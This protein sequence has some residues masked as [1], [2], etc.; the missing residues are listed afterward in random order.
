MPE[1]KSPLQRRPAQVQ[2]AVLRTKVL[3]SIT[4]FLY[5]ERRG[6]R[7]VKYVDT[8]DFDFDFSGWNLRVL[9]LTLENLSSDLNHP[10]T[11]QRFGR[12]NEF[13]VCQRIDYKLGDAV[14][15]AKIYEG[16]SS[17]FAGLLNPARKG[18]C[19]SFVGKP[20]LT[21]GIASVHS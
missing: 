6:N 19:L 3:A 13:G 4:V 15:V 1:G 14:A 11:A 2:V 18:Y 17:E 5:G 8:L 12:M 20:E 7:F 9:A 10:L 16:H 21:A